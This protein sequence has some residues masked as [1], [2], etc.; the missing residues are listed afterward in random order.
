MA[1]SQ[2]GKGVVYR[3]PQFHHGI[4]LS[5]GLAQSYEVD[6]TNQYFRKHKLTVFRYLE[7]EGREVPCTKE[8]LY[9]DPKKAVA[10]VD[11]NTIGICAILGSTVRILLVIDCIFY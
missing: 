5:G 6:I 11:E 3:E 4:E 9:M 8:L 7:I 10:L 1:I 2:K